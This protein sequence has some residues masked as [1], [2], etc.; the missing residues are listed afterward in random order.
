M[1][2]LALFH[3]ILTLLRHLVAAAG[4][5][6]IGLLGTDQAGALWAASFRFVKVFNKGTYPGN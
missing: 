2:S 6:L 4:T 3:L 1:H 5:F